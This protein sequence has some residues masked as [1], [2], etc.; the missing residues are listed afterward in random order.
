M[1][2][3]NIC[4]MAVC[5]CTLT[6]VAT[7]Q[8]GAALLRQ[9]GI[10]G[11]VVVHVGCGDGLLTE[12]LHP[13]PQYC[14]QGL[15]SD[16]AAVSA[17]RSR[18]VASGRYGAVT[19]DRW[20]GQHL[21]Y[22][23]NF[24]NLI[25]VQDAADASMAELMRVLAPNGV[26][27]QQ[28]DGQWEKTVK[29]WPA[30]MDEW[31]HYLHGPDGN[32][33]GKD[34]LVAPPKRLQWLG[35][36]GWS[37]HHDHMAS[38]TSLVSAG[39]RLFYILDEGS[40]ASIQLPSHWRL[41]AR[42]AFNGTI[43][44]KR[45]IPEWASKDFGLKSGPAHL[46]RRLVAVG[47][48]VYVTLGIDAPTSILDAAT[49]ETLSTC[50]ASERTREIVVAD[51][52]A[53]LVVGHEKSRLPDFRRVGTYTWSNTRAS[54]TG[55]GWQGEVRSIVACDASSGK[56]RWQFA[57][58]VAPCSLAAN[59]SAIVL[60][61]GQRLVCLD[62][63]TGKPKWQ[64]EETP[65]KMPV[66]S[67]TGPRVLI[68]QDMILLAIND[69]K[70]SGWSLD[71]GQKV[72]E[73]AQKPSG[74]MS[75]KDLF[76]VD[77]LAWTAAIASSPD[78]GVWIGYDPQ[79]GEKKREFAPDVQLHWFHH[80]CYPSKASGNF[81][82]TGRNGTEYVDLQQE[83][84]TPN[85]W[86]RGGCIYGIMPCNGMTYAS[87][88]A[89][90]C[91]LEAKLSGF[92]AL[93]PS[94][95][96]Q[97]SAEDLAGES[98]LE[99]GPAYGFQGPPAGS[100]D[101]PTFRHDPARSAATGAGLTPSGS[102]WT[103]ELGGRLTQP[104]IA[105]GRV[106]VA[107]RDTHTLHALDADTGEQLWSYTTGG[108]TD[109]PPTYVNGLVI[110]GSADGYV[111]ALRARDGVLAWRF[112]AA[113]V[114]QRMMDGEQIESA[115][116]VHGSVLAREDNGQTVVYCTA[117]RSIYLDGGIRFLRLDAATGKLL[118]EVVWN[119]MDPESGQNMHDAYL[120]KTPGNTMPVGL[121]DV[122][123][124]DGRNIWMRSQKIDFEGQRSEM[125][126]LPATDQPPED[127]HLFC[128]VGFVDDSYFFRS[129][130][131]YGR[132]M[133]GGYGGWY[134]AG[135]YVPSGRILCFDDNAVYGYGRKPEYMVNSSVIE[136]QLFA[137]DKAV[138]PENIRRVGEAERAMNQ[139]RPD[140]NAASSDW[141][142]RWFYP[143]EE[144]TAA[145]YPW[146]LDQPSVTARAMCVAGD[147][148]FV[149]GPPDVVDERYAYH[150]PDVPDV[151]ALLA[152][153]E[154]AYAGEQGGQ[155]WVVNKN[156][157]QVT[158]RYALDTIPVF[159]G[160]AAANGRLYASTIDGRVTSFTARGLETLP[161]L[162]GQ[163][164]QTKW[165]EPEDPKYLLPLP[166]PKDADF[167]TVRGC[168]VFA[169]ELGYRLRANTQETLA[170]AVKKLDQPI[171]GTVTFRMRLRAV[172]ETQGLLRNGYLAF[173]NSARE[174]D[175]VKC[176]V[177]LQPQRA[178]I[179]Q[180]P[181]QAD[182]P[183]TVSAAVDAPEATGLEAV[184]TVD[185]AAQT[186]KYV[187]NGVELQA[188]LKTPLSKITH[189]GY[190]LDRRI[191]RRDTDRDRAKRLRVRCQA[192]ACGAARDH[193]CASIQSPTPVDSM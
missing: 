172:P 30:E 169:S 38:M 6:C 112:R 42:D 23:D 121:S 135:R 136:Y 18:L 16:P 45:D 159:D 52:T 101:W 56:L 81:L 86:F 134:Q 149:A 60:H 7:A 139:R 189:V 106:F 156:N 73:Q 9:S 74:H 152:H 94:P 127:A 177:R 160:M 187:A 157:G 145:R 191:D 151:Q 114:D 182:K 77:G 41:I 131:T 32:P 111:Y 128:Q 115:W 91:Q 144:L 31:T 174:A 163:P 95:V 138:T 85:H 21:P 13:G 179:I 59:E 82:I 146:L 192:I 167:A 2:K 88:D 40:R 37:R 62:R 107:A 44:W 126:V 28:R 185:L 117:G 148:L 64:A 100:T 102:N 193:R 92:K 1:N 103:A 132:R 124:C 90:G 165:S 120:R 17:I 97:L 130:W 55:W 141:R 161:S 140:K 34:Q 53:L 188:K 70:V 84:W 180:G 12:Q 49:G 93:S 150:N 66:D 129:Y 61:D 76:V 164:L 158:A 173:G 24:V 105:D 71:D 68:Y 4:L 46:L 113:P 50:E 33:V 125:T 35:G 155:L 47:D 142:L 58:P 99:R 98:R 118:G 181:F 57:S 108:Q 89:C 3:L 67:N 78:D 8:D 20:D 123:S 178:S 133:T 65:L 168:K 137:A 166:E 170:V 176:G 147:Q 51:D 54:N 119:E 79:T 43:L 154:E 122:L 104:T 186:V 75:L 29:P 116:P 11:G 19:V 5:F 22:V 25:V 83:H 48:R 153:Q 109:T 96:P 184:V 63:R 175:L 69:G 72:W 110:F 80:R 190:V 183:T 10:H 27:L 162:E 36:P 26:M 143:K 14:V 171:S 87:M 15:T 39:G